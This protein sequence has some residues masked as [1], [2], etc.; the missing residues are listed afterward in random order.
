VI[1]L[2]LWFILQALP[3]IGHISIPLLTSGGVAYLAHVGGFLFG[4]AMIKPFVR[5]ARGL[6]AKPAV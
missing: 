5:W 1:V 6:R 2:G 4:L 3:G